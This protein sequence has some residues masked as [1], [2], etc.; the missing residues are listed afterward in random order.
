VRRHCNALERLPVALFARGPV[1]DKPESWAGARKQLDRALAA[2]PGMDP[3]DVRLFGG[4][5]KPEQL[6]F[7]FSNMPAADVR[8]WVAIRAWGRGLPERLGLAGYF[9]SSKPWVIA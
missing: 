3:V 5:V 7:P 1:D 2:L 4:A 8:D 9:S 6:H